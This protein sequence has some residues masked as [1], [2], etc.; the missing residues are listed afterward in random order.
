MYTEGDVNPVIAHLD[1]GHP[2]VVWL[3]FWGN[4]RETKTDDGTYAVFSGMH[5]LTAYGYDDGGIYLMD[6]AKGHS[7]YYDWATFK[8]LWTPIDGMSMAVY[9][10]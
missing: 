8:Q 1:A 10:M 6:P 4:T 3:A 7:V 9:P 5:V 2:V